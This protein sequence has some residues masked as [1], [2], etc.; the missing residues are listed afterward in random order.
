MAQ[1]S[2]T[3]SLASGSRSA[4]A[5]SLRGSRAEIER[6][7]LERTTALL[8]SPS[9]LDPQFV[10]GQ[11]AAISAAIDF[12][13]AAVEVGERRL[14][15][16]PALFHSRARLTARS[17]V[18]LDNTLRRYFAGYTLLTDFLM[19][20]AS[21]CGTSGETLQDMMRDTATAFDRLVSTVTE[22]YVREADVKH[23]TREAR[24]AA[25]VAALIDGE[26]LDTADFSYEF[27]NAWHLGAVVVG[28]G[29]PETMRGLA[30]AMGCQLLTVPHE[31]GHL[32]AWLGARQQ[33]DFARIEGQL[34]SCPAGV[35]IAFGEPAYG[36]FGW[37][38]THR[39][40]RAV[41]P[42]VKRVSESHLRYG[43]AA[44][45]ASMLQDDLLA[46]SLRELYLRPLEG[47]RDGGLALRQTL[48]AY[49]A[50]DRNVSSA[51]A[52]LGISRRTVTNRL[53]AIEARIN[54]TLSTVATEI[55]AALRLH[56][57]HDREASA[58]T[59]L[60]ARSD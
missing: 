29:G 52:A 27:G 6:A 45:T 5:S 1:I 22:E 10:D 2:A 60:L 11:R 19:R 48:R 24:I 25:R 14:A 7:V 59:R 17:G 47:E 12:G 21:K 57:L 35:S 43:E 4:V 8:E 31:R 38:L 20:E 32:W 58:A 39:Q 40:A 49:F 44:L 34:G 30:A 36:I 55:D 26:L 41:L 16:V 3:R 18:S 13:L 28:E 50:S 42:V 56:E 46:T 53:R 51:A 54:R 33:P 15:D 37:R 9:G 23:C